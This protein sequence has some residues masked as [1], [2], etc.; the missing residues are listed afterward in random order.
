[1]NKTNPAFSWVF[2]ISCVKLNNLN[3]FQQKCLKL[4]VDQLIHLKLD[5]FSS[6]MIFLV[7]V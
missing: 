5:G 3:Y 2:Y 4:D 1:M 6:N 7:S